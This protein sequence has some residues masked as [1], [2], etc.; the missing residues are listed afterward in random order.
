MNATCP[1]CG[2]RFQRDAGYFLGSIYFNY[3]VTGLLTVTLYFALYFGDLLTDPQRLA[4][5]GLFVVVFPAWFFRYA[6]ALWV[7]LDEWL[8]PW[9][10]AD[11]LR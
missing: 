6:R 7:A 5:L 1:D 8:D 2:R 9:P 4:L 3:A 10:N 11:E